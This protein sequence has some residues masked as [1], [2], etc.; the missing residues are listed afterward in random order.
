MGDLVIIFHDNALKNVMNIKIQR[1]FRPKKAALTIIACLCLSAFF[2][3]S[4]GA[5]DNKVDYVA[6][7]TGSDLAA[8]RA[9]YTG[10]AEKYSGGFM[11]L[12]KRASRDKTIFGFRRPKDKKYFESVVRQMTARA[13]GSA[14]PEKCES[15]TE[16]VS[17]SFGRDKNAVGALYAYSFLVCAD[18]PSV[19]PA[20]MLDKYVEKYGPYDARDWDRDER[21]YYKVRERYKVMV[22]PLKT[23]SGNAGLMITVVDDGVFD[24]T[25]VEARAR[26]RND[27]NAATGKF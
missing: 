16:A 24:R 18:D 12:E 15:P 6:V 2:P 8:F 19:T 17:L 27:E 21:V 23:A 11:E 9:R 22:R 13:Y 10:L 20:R 26:I 25:Y 7:G 4:A 14:A 3:P 1:P 5:H